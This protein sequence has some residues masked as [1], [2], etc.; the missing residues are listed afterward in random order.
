MTW[1]RDEFVYCNRDRSYLHIN[2]ETISFQS[3]SRFKW[4]LFVYKQILTHGSIFWFYFLILFFD[5]ICYDSISIHT[6]ILLI[7]GLLFGIFVAAVLTDQL[8][9]IFTDE[10]MIEKCQHQRGFPTKPRSILLKELFG[11]GSMLLWLLPCRISSKGYKSLD[12]IV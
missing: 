8:Q 7:F 6:I 11:S 2:R 5:F 12:M 4:L 1:S 10:T 3:V 9:G